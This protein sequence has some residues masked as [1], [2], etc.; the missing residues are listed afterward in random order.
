VLLVAA[1]RHAR[2]GGCFSRV[3]G[4][5]GTR[6][7]DSRS[8]PRALT[9]ATHTFLRVSRSLR[10]AL[11]HSPPLA[12]VAIAEARSACGSVYRSTPFRCLCVVPRLRRVFVKTLLALTL[13]LITREMASERSLRSARY[14]SEAEALV[15]GRLVSSHALPNSSPLFLLHARSAVARFAG[16]LLTPRRRA[17]SRLLRCQVLLARLGAAIL[18]SYASPPR[19]L[20]PLRC[21][22]QGRG[23]A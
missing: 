23:E 2:D 15:F 10:R 19:S 17:L 6:A 3:W 21:Q 16:A 7:S 20:S 5:G 9:P 8:P 4:G 13:H 1:G 11:P 18:S 14:F 12:L 22:A